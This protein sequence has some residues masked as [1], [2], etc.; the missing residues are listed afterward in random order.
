MPCLEDLELSGSSM[1]E[2]FNNGHR[3]KQLFEHIKDVQLDDLECL[4]NSS[5]KDTLLAT[6]NDDINGY[7]FD[8]TCS[9]RHNKAY[10]SAFG[11]TQ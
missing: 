9:I 4:T 1:G 6:F 7:W 3:L 11:H 8:V 2:N 10:I 5:S